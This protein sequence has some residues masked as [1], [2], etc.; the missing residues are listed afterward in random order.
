[1]KNLVR[2]SLG[3]AVLGLVVASA[4]VQTK[5]IKNGVVTATPT[6]APATKLR[7]GAIVHGVIDLSTGE[8]R[9]FDTNSNSQRA[10]IPAFDNWSWADS[11]EPPDLVRNYNWLDPGILVLCEFNDPNH[12]PSFLYTHRWSSDGC[13]DPND[14]DRA[15]P[16]L[17]GESNNLDI[18][19]DNYVV[20]PSVWDE[21]G[22]AGSDPILPDPN[23]TRELCQIDVIVGRFDSGTAIPRVNETIGIVI[24]FYEWLDRDGD[25][26]F[27]QVSTGPWMWVV[28]L[29]APAQWLLLL[30]TDGTG[31]APYGLDMI[32]LD[33]AD[34]T[35]DPNT[36]EFLAKEACG[37]YGTIAGGLTLEGTDLYNPNPPCPSINDRVNKGSTSHPWFDLGFG[38]SD[39]WVWSN[40]FADPNGTPIDPNLN[41]EPG[42]QYEDI[43][44]GGLGYVVSYVTGGASELNP[45]LMFALYVTEANVPTCGP[46][47]TIDGLGDADLDDDC[48]VDLTDLAI[49]LSAFESTSAGDTDGDGD[50][51]LTD[52]A[53]L[54]SKF[55]TLCP[56]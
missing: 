10:C 33:I 39:I 18:M 21:D 15:T 17:V 34:F 25:A 53:R 8:Y 47:C 4:Q 42:L 13:I 27:G 36:G 29:P 48:D 46:E 40:G 49:L 51:D 52:L 20:D 30:G 2:V 16:N 43:W 54:L 14:H 37:Y 28:T 44:A 55:D 50:T 9:K 32:L 26:F 23:S 56:P 1:M 19:F 38:F 41:G 7:T 35:I 5:Q 22:T 12:P 24:G 11:L 31:L 6:I 45:S 3:V